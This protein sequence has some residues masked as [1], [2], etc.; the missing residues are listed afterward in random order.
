MLDDSFFTIVKAIK[1]GRILRDN[2]KKA[3][4]QEAILMCVLLAI[5]VIGVTAT[6]ESPISDIQLLWIAIIKTL[7]ALVLA[8]DSESRNVFDRPGDR[9]L[10]SFITGAMKRNIICQTIY[11]VALLLIVLF[12]G[13][14]I[15]DLGEMSHSDPYVIYLFDE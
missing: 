14:N 11:Q 5:E 1:F 4:Q 7:F 3:V 2:I 13:S 8:T 9:K 15:L 10:D 6:V 12:A